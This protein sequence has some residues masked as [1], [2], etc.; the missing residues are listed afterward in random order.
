MLLSKG[1]GGLSLYLRYS[2]PPNLHWSMHLCN[3]QNVAY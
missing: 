3:P 2:P 1:V